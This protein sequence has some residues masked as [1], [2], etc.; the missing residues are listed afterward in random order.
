MQRKDRWRDTYR[1]AV[2]V[3][4]SNA[5]GFGLALLQLVLVLELGSHGDDVRVVNKA[6]INESR[7]IGECRCVRCGRM[8]V[9]VRRQDG[10]QV[11]RWEVKTKSGVSRQ[12]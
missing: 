11:V 9:C 10:M 3:L 2:S 1:N 4:L 8:D 7:G 12:H 6:L 5:V